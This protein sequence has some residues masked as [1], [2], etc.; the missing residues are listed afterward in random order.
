MLDLHKL[1][2]KDWRGAPWYKRI[3]GLLGATMGI[4]GFVFAIIVANIYL[5]CSSI[6]YS[7][8]A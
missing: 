1:E 2:E 3:S 4:D 7:S 8:E 5:Q 6:V